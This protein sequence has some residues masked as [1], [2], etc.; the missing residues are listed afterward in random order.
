MHDLNLLAIA[1]A[2]LSAFFLGGLWYS[3]ILFGKAWLAHANAGE[4]KGHPVIVYATSFIFALVSAGLFA[5][6]LGPKPSLEMGVGT[7]LV[8][9]A[10]F[11]AA[12]FGIN[13]QFSNRSTTL[14]MID[15]GYHIVQFALYGLIL[16]MWH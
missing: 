9:G 12:S 8:V 16:G 5:Y 2:A 1:A 13:Y 15:G 10:G 6:L 3:P 11:V 14:W 7:G 4:Q